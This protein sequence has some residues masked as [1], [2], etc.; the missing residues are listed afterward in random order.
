MRRC[1]AIVLA[2]LVGLGAAVPADS[3]SVG[4]KG[5][6]RRATPVGATRGN[7][8]AANLSAPRA[9]VPVTRAAAPKFLPHPAASPV[10]AGLSGKTIKPSSAGRV[11]GAAPYDA[12]HGAVIGGAA[13]GRRR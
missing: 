4:G 8:M 9:S 12:R 13:I 10:V 11:G 1:A 2:C 5:V 3:A 7:P 6:M